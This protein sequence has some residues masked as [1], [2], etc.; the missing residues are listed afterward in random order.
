[1]LSFLS[2]DER[3]IVDIY[4]LVHIEYGVL[5]RV[6]QVC[7]ELLVFSSGCGTIRAYSTRAHAADTVLNFRK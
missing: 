6:Q 1:M 7:Q 4:I 2:I 5:Y 3:R